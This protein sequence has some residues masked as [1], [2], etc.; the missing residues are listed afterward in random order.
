MDTAAPNANLVIWIVVPVFLVSFVGLWL[1]VLVVIG[2]LSGWATLAQQF[3]SGN[4]FEGEVW[5][6]QSAR[7]RGTNFNSCLTIGSSIRGLYLALIAPLRFRSPALLIPW[8]E[9]TVSRR[10]VFLVEL[11]CLE[12]GREQKI[13]FCIRPHLA[14][15]LQ[16]AAGGYWPAQSSIG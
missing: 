8:G 5:K 10:R 12:L 2:K 16:R 3:P 1:L 4:S 9:I 15:R 11:V 6:W 7:M 13:S 14:E